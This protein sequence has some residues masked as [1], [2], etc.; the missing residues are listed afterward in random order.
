MSG[1]QGLQYYSVD[2]TKE[3]FAARMITIVTPVLNGLERLPNCLASV[4]DGSAGAVGIEHIVQDGGST[5]GTVVWLQGRHSRERGPPAGAVTFHWSSEPDG[6]LYDALNKGFARAT[7]DILAWLNADEQYLPGALDRVAGF[8][9]ANPGIDILAGDFL[10]T[11]PAGHLLAARRTMKPVWPL[12]AAS[13]LY[14]FSCALFFRR[15]VWESGL[16]FDVSYRVVGD[17]D[18]VVRALRSGFR[19]A[20]IRA[21]LSAHTLRPG[22]LSDTPLAGEERRRLKSAYPGGIRAASPLLNLARLAALAWSGA[23]SRPSTIAY[24][25]FTKEDGPRQ[26]FEAVRPSNRWP[27]GK[28]P[29]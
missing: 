15:R 4:A 25:L 9:A 5:D 2:R 12:I 3:P 17:E 22:R 26:R 16:R 20:H 27:V 6:G 13:Y 23:G 18:F 7:G 24:E 11:G 29:K 8:F 28:E 21:F 10:V 1:Q 14:A 19:A